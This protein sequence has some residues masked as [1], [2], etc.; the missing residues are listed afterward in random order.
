MQHHVYAVWDYMSLVKALQNY[1]APVTVPWVPIKNAQSANFINQIVLDEESDIAFSSNSQKSHASHFESYLD[2][3]TE[4]GADTEIVKEFIYSVSE[5]GIDDA[6]KNSKIPAPAKEFMGFTFDVIKYAKPHLIAAMLAFGR[7]E[8]LPQLFQ[9]FN[10]NSFIENIKA[11]SLHAYVDRHIEL[12]EHEH[13]PMAVSMVE[14]LCEGSLEKRAEV[15]EITEL[16]LRSRLQFWNGIK[17]AI[18]IAFINNLQTPSI[19]Q[20]EIAN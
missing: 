2:A 17:S 13:G 20:N 8:L 18:E 6:L 14:E 5:N 11:P 19:F 3:M 1:I 12:D 4:V 10:K 16:V 15:T 9:I 7:E